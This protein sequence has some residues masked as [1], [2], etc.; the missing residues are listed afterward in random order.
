MG[1]IMIYIAC[2]LECALLGTRNHYPNTPLPPCKMTHIRYP[3]PYLHAFLIHFLTFIAPG[4]QRALGT[5]S[6]RPFRMHAGSLTLC[7][8][9][10]RH[11][12]SQVQPSRRVRAAHLLFRA[13]RRDSERLAGY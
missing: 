4:L 7:N 5:Y 2:M 11:S 13:R 10:V 12:K 1:L 9:H 3:E 6:N 8:Y